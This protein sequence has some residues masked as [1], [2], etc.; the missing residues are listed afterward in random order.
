LLTS[1]H[2]A[3]LWVQLTSIYGP[4]FTSRNGSKDGGLWLEALQ[5]LT[6]IAL[7][8]GMSRIKKLSAGNK[9]TEFPPNCLQFKALCLAYYEDLRLPKASDAYQEIR[10]RAYSN[11]IYWSHPVVKF[12]AQKLTVDFLDIKLEAEAYRR[13]KEIYNDVCHLVRQGLELP[14]TEHRV[15]IART[16]NKAIAKHHLQSIKQQLGA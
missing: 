7:E 8:S 1:H 4:L 12:I 5:D 2:I 13:F 6:P 16:P 11:T 9:F 3:W 10:N 14:K 15:M